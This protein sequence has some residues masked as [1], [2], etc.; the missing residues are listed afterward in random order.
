MITWS[1][2]K[3]MD[4]STPIQ[5]EVRNWARATDCNTVGVK[6]TYSH[7]P[8][9]VC[10]SWEPTKYHSNDQEY[11]ATLHSL[12]HQIMKQYPEQEW[13][14][15]TTSLRML[16]SQ[17]S[18]TWE[19]CVQTLIIKCSSVHLSGTWIH[20]EWHHITNGETSL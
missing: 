11:C 6:C 9:L 4:L 16:T 1:S 10:I 7:D 5:M 19:Q 13:K 12:R 17:I 20:P 18:M 3:T 14:V 2:E 15:D 8:N